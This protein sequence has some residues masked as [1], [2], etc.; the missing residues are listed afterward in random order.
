[1]AHFAEL[2]ENNV[3]LRVCVVNNNIETS[4]GPLGENDK[5]IDGEKWCEDFWGGKWKQTSYNNNFRKRYA[6]IGM[7][8]DET[9][10]KFLEPQPFSSWSLDGNDDWKAPVT[11]PTV[12]EYDWDA[13]NKA[14]S[15]KA[16]EA[17]GVTWKENSETGSWDKV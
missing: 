3:V 14:P 12:L 15:T 7:I 10:D 13:S 2:D 5:H 16:W 4:D 6:G 1:M 11:H 8:Y 9:K 17:D